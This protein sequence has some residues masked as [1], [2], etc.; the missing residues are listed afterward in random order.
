MSNLGEVE[1]A[2]LLQIVLEDSCE[3]QDLRVRAAALTLAD[4]VGLLPAI[5]ILESAT[6]LESVRS[7]RKAVQLL[8]RAATALEGQREAL[9]LAGLS[10]GGI[11]GAYAASVRHKEKKS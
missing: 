4:R 2:N 1:L 8:E 9:S 11:A 3:H 10:Y 7:S 6:A 5:R